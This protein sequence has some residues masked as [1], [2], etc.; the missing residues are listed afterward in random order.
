MI[1]WQPD[2]ARKN[3]RLLTP[4]L[5]NTR[6]FMSLTAGAGTG[7]LGLLSSSPSLCSINGLEEKTS[8]WEPQ[9]SLR[10][11]V[12]HEGSTDCNSGPGLKRVR[13]SLSCVYCR[14]NL[15]ERCQTAAAGF[16]HPWFHRIYLA[17][18]WFGSGETQ[19]REWFSPSCN[20]SRAFMIRA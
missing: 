19:G 2:Q 3:H 14:S 7:S 17:I 20:C 9:S 13:A 18:C 15:L 11:D 1:T 4:G 8:I 16:Q 5:D 10:L 12:S 6:L